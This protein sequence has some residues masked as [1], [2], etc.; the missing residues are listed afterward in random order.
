MKILLLL[1][2]SFSATTWASPSFL[3]PWEEYSKPEIMSTEFVR[4]FYELPL[5]GEV[6]DKSRYWSSD[7]WP[8]NKG[9]INQRWNSPDQSGFNL[10][11]PTFEEALKMGQ[12]ELAAL[13][14]S[15][16]FDL[17]NGHYDYPLKKAVER[18]ASPDDEIWEGICQGW[19]AAALNHKEPVPRNM[20]N[21]QGL[22]IP[23]GSSDIKALLSYYYAY[24]HEVYDFHQMG[25]RCSR[26][27]KHC[28][29]DL[30]AGAFHIA[31]A[32]K[33]GLLGESF[34]ADIENTKEVWNQVVYSY[35]SEIL[36]EDLPPDVNSAPGTV[37]VIRMKTNMVV[38]FNISMNSW[39]P[40]IGTENQTFRS[41][42]YE[43]DLDIDQEGK[44]IGGTWKSQLRPDFIWFVRRTQDFGDAFSRLKYLLLD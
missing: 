44:I 2:T 26:R 11:S 42:V 4:T 38:V 19:A 17:Y 41:N 20:S 37:K 36:D 30:N 15:E 21:P 24:H 22:T 29:E 34:I 1:L 23:F 39:M 8:M 18:R 31:L 33:T 9:G 6:R 16:K 43:Y 25:K 10:V 13:S 27:G 5:K 12:R 35:D 40:S 14:P 7:Y 3:K 28:D 32:N